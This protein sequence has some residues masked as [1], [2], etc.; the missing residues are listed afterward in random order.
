MTLLKHL[1]VY[2]MKKML[3]SVRDDLSFDFE[4]PFSAP[5]DVSCLRMVSS[6]VNNEISQYNRGTIEYD[7]RPQHS[8]RSLYYVG[9]FDCD[10][11]DIFPEKP[12]FICKLCDSET[13]YQSLLS[14][15]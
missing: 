6:Q 5:T 3:Y 1:E 14:Q 10:T 9:S 2:Y 7:P 4:P 11:G 8:T 12:V 15:M 13:V